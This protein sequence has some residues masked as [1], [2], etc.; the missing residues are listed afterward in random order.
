MKYPVIKVFKINGNPIKP[1]KYQKQT[2]RMDLAIIKDSIAFNNKQNKLSLTK[3]DIDLL[4][5][6]AAVNLVDI[7]Q[8]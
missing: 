8:K 4:A 1:T 6:N 5:W 3:S 2:F 7:T